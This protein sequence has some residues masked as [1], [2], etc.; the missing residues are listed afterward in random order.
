MACH[1]RF[2]QNRQIASDITIVVPVYNTAVDYLD[3]CIQS[4]LLQT[5]KPHEVLIID[6]GSRLASTRHHLASFGALPG[7]RLVRNDRN[8]NLGPTMNRALALCSTPFALKFDSDDIA[9]PQMVEKH[10]AFL[11]DNP[12]IDVLGCQLQ[13]FGTTNFVTA[14]PA[15]V[16]KHYAMSH[17][18]FI[19]NGGSI[20]NV[21]SVLTAGGY[22]RTRWAAEDYELWTR[23]LLLGFTRF[24]NL[25]DVLFEWRVL[26]TGLNHKSRPGS[27]IFKW[28]RKRSLRT[29][30]DF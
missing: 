15:R 8:L 19:N 21:E 13:T 9:R 2:A 25:P 30:P 22:R 17:N 10:A 27:R 1:A 28:W 18:W 12:D 6:D 14:H 20:L 3:E 23:M 7:F 4:V 24:Y 11:A 26:P 29:C 5:V 16:T